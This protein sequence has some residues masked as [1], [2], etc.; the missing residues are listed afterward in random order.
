[1]TAS[2][3]TPPAEV[4][5]EVIPP[6]RQDLAIFG[7]ETFKQYRHWCS[8]L[9]LIDGLKKGARPRQNFIDRDRKST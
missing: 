2:I 1:M 7:F 8:S 5:F 3:P 6:L 4:A 9:G